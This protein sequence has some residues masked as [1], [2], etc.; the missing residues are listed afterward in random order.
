MEIIK[1]DL[2]KRSYQ[3]SN[4][5][6]ATLYKHETYTY[7]PNL[8]TYPLMIICPGGGYHNLSDRNMEPVALKL[9]S[10]GYQVIILEYS[11]LNKTEPQSVLPQPLY[12][13]AE[14]IAFARQH[15]EAFA[16]AEN[17]IYIMG[18]SAGGHL[19]ALYNGLFYRECFQQA[20]GYEASL[21]KPDA[22]VLAYP[23]ISLQADWPFSHDRI[24][25]ITQDQTLQAAQELVSNQ[26]SPVFIWHTVEDQRVGVDN[27]L[28]YINAL[29]TWKVKFEA[30][31]FQ[32]GEHG[33]SLA[34]EL[35]SKGTKESQDSQAATWFELSMHW[36]NALHEI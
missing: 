8:K 10:E 2:K 4:Q 19:C 33:L 9:L 35:T 7:N 31:L 22:V 20:A 29:N 12:E 36:L 34:T 1:I 23:V 16:I 14:V 15:H 5:V 17:R 28:L 18:F 26:S 30:H 11:L 24:L 32:T 6:R 21:I 13:L 25:E 27:S 3:S